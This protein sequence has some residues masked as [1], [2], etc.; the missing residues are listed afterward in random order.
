[1]F[2]PETENVARKTYRLKERGKPLASFYDRLDDDQREAV[3]KSQG[4]SLVI[5]GPGSGKTHVITYKVAHLIQS[6]MLPTD[7]LLVTFTR[8]AAREMI[9]R[10]QALVRRD[11]SDMLAGTFHHVCNRLLR[12]YGS[13]V[14][15]APNFTI[16]DRDDSISL[17]KI[18]RREYL[19][20]NFA[21]EKQPKVLAP[22]A[23]ADLYAY[24]GNVLISLREAVLELHPRFVPSLDHLEAIYRDYLRRKA[25]LNA[26]DYDDLQIY[27]MRL[28][29]ENPVIAQKI[30][31]QFRWVLVDEFQDT[32]L[33]QAQLAEKW[34]AV[35]GN[36]MVVGDDAQSI[37]SFRGARYQ[38]ILDFA[39]HPDC[40]VFKI[41]NNYR[42][43]RQIVAFI[44]EMIP[45][46]VFQKELRAVKGDGPKPIIAITLDRDQQA[47]FVTQRVREFIAADVPLNEM[48]ILYRSHSHSLEVQIELT[49]AGIP[50]EIY[51]GVKFTES[52]H[53][54][55]VLSFLRLLTN[56]RDQIAW[57]RA[58]MLFEGIGK[59]TAGR[60]SSRIL[61]ALEG[62]RD[63][64]VE[65]DQLIASKQAEGF[66]G[67]KGL[68]RKLRLEK[69]PGAM[70]QRILREFYKD[71]LETHFANYRERQ[72]DLERL[73]EIANRYATC[74]QFLAD[75]LLAE[76]DLDR[77]AA[78]SEEKKLVLT[79]VHQAKG[80]EWDVVFV[81]SVNPGDF[82]SRWAVMEGN[83]D[84]ERRVFYVAITRPRRELIICRQMFTPAFS[85]ELIY[86]DQEADFLANVPEELVEFWNVE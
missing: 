49:H 55:D 36:L 61:Q 21:K 60:I 30:S 79:T 47:K 59:A 24:M 6:G 40:R 10:S 74:Q 58:L 26:L 9:H 63:P 16:L 56:P 17:L 20:R 48:G 71:Y 73:A 86:D 72:R 54:K 46:N 70:I 32:S 25:Q 23:L 82:P 69:S 38:N 78:P 65:L 84:E 77:E 45:N 66:E 5:A 68:I 19:T 67:F 2:S 29:E 43:T 53:V 27:V 13:H 22:R 85:D 18:S 37:Y 57:D 8:R 76:D 62:E 34:A 14:G 31:D 35:H 33:I 75:I 7:I 28:L 15:V 83:L 4:R 3:L 80:L 50:F 42:S 11:L 12:R 52:A 64:F 1:M 81:L 51:S 44:N 39:R 41:Q